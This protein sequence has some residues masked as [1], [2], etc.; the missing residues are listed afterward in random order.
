MSM[1]NYKTF[2]R[3]FMSWKLDFQH[4]CWDIPSVSKI[5]DV[6]L[7]ISKL[8]MH[9]HKRQ[10]RYMHLFHA[11]CTNNTYIKQS[12]FLFLFFPV[13]TPFIHVI[14]FFFSKSH[15]IF[16]FLLKNLPRISDFVYCCGATACST[17]FHH[18]PLSS[19]FYHL[20]CAPHNLEICFQWSHVDKIIE[21]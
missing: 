15:L 13:T 17:M 8:N 3:K 6:D 5:S 11:V 9:I 12:H 20:F 19:N 7:E 18:A 4:S 10:T 21:E 16:G 14:P 1:S 2:H